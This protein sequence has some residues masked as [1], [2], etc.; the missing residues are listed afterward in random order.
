MFP[1]YLGGVITGVFWLVTALVARVFDMPDIA[2]GGALGMLIP[3]CIGL[4]KCE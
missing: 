4:W 1:Y 2:I 3:M